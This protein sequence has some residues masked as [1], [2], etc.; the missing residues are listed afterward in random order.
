MSCK[1]SFDRSSILL[2]GYF[3]VIL[4]FF[5]TFF[6]YVY[7]E[8]DTNK[9]TTEIIP[10]TLREANSEKGK[11]IEPEI[12]R[13]CNSQNTIVFSTLQCLQVLQV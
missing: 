3:V 13:S 6:F 2:Y 1:A 11:E 10:E 9:Q 4:I 8:G 7:A 5:L 12:F